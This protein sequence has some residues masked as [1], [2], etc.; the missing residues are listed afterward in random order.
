MYLARSSCVIC[1]EQI[2]KIQYNLKTTHSKKSNQLL[3]KLVEDLYRNIAFLHCNICT[4]CHDLLNELDLVQ[5]REKE[6]YAQL[7][8][9]ISKVEASK[10]SDMVSSK[11]EPENLDETVCLE[12]PDI[13]LKG[14]PIKVKRVKCKSEETTLKKK[15]VLAEVRTEDQNEKMFEQVCTVSLYLT[16]ANRNRLDSNLNSNGPVQT[17][18][19]TAEQKQTHSKYTVRNMWTEF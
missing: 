17:C 7:K 13:D 3:I 18:G 1:R 12:I 16:L 4:E 9:Y 14:L 19:G 2:D 15:P 5:Y 11:L 6:L 10:T 8:T